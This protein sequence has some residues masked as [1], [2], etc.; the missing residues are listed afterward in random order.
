MGEYKMK[1]YLSAFLLL[2]LI[3]VIS[4]CGAA[5]DSADHVTTTITDSSNASQQSTQ[6]VPTATPIPEDGLKSDGNIHVYLVGSGEKVDTPSSSFISYIT[7]YSESEHLIICMNGKEYAFANVPLSVWSDFK[8]A[9]SA[10]TFYNQ[11]IKGNNAYY[12][13]DYDGSNGDLIVLEYMN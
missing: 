5:S 3:L 6:P 7:Y 11:N 13:N 10:G 4:A 1:K 9:D 12:I 2:A 8:A